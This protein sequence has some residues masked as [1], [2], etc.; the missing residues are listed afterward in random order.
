MREGSKDGI[1]I[2]LN[3][4]IRGAVLA[5]NLCTGIEVRGERKMDERW[6]GYLDR[7]ALLTI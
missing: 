4:L 6:A 1:Y 3:L 7:V 5:R 2:R